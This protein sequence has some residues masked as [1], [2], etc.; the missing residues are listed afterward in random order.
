MR[1][2][3]QD[4]LFAVSQDNP[5]EGGFLSGQKIVLRTSFGKTLWT[6]SSEQNLHGVWPSADGQYFV[7]FR[8]GSV[9]EIRHMKNGSLQRALGE[10][11]VDAVSMNNKRALLA[12]TNGQ[13]GKIVVH[14]AKQQR[15]L[16]SLLAEHLAYDFKTGQ[17][18][19]SY[20]SEIRVHHNDGNV[21]QRITGPDHITDINLSSDGKRIIVY[22]RENK[23]FVWKRDGTPV[24][25]SEYSYLP[26]S[27]VMVMRLGKTIQGSYRSKQVAFHGKKMRWQTPWLNGIE[28]VMSVDGRWLA[29]KSLSPHVAV[30]HASTHF[31]RLNFK[32]GQMSKTFTLKPTTKDPHSAWGIAALH[33]QGAMA[34]LDERSGDGCGWGLYGFQLVNLAQAK[35]LP[36]PKAL[37]KGY[38]V[39][40]GCGVYRPIPKASFA[41]DGK[42][43]IQVGNRLDWWD[44]P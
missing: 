28:A 39:S 14:S 37:A 43:L 31:Q 17:F 36:I 1:W 3:G 20:G 32:T 13:K 5:D 22:A 7:S 18:L 34:L 42:L 41:P 27:T 26:T 44:V 24:K 6:L 21:M 10:A 35:R 40:S 38:Q 15:I 25:L 33:P 4:L 30:G 19:S 2:I 12:I 9:P 29:S 23:M 8:A 11:V 16:T